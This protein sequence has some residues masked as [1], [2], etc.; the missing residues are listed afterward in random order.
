MRSFGVHGL[1]T[2]RSGYAFLE[3][4]DTTK[5]VYPTEDL[6]PEHQL[7]VQT[8]LRVRR[9]YQQQILI[10]WK[11]KRHKKGNEDFV[12]AVIDNM[13]TGCDYAETVLNM[14]KSFWFMES[15]EGEPTTGFVGNRFHDFVISEVFHLQ[16]PPEKIFNI[17]NGPE[18]EAVSSLLQWLLLSSWSS[19]NGD[20]LRTNQSALEY[21]KLVIGDSVELLFWYQ[22]IYFSESSV[23]EE[24]QVTTAVWH[25]WMHKNEIGSCVVLLLK[26]WFRTW[27]SLL[28]CWFINGVC[29]QQDDALEVECFVLGAG[30]FKVAT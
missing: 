19:R 27:E 18:S 13:N 10:L 17:E 11:K 9:E 4:S 21:V 20:S 2:L 22:E 26:R 15:W 24:L 16:R 3:T 29:L 6:I 25:L 5:P 14:L 7:F 23:H 1:K 12:E 30:V 8:V 28:L